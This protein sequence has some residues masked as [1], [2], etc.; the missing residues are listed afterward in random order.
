MIAMANNTNQDQEVLSIEAISAGL[1]LLIGEEVLALLQQP[2]FQAG[3]DDLYESSSWGTV[4]QSRSFV[5]TWYEAYRHEYLPILVMAEHQ[6]KLI[7][8]LTMARDK[9]GHIVGAGHFEAEYQT[10]LSEKAIGDAFIQAALGALMERFPRHELLFRFLPPQTPLNWLTG[11]NK[12]RRRS[13]LVEYSRPLMNFSDPDFS[14]IARHS[15]FRNKLNRLKRLGEVRFERIKEMEKFAAILDRLI[16]LFDFRQGAM[17]NLSQFRD[18]PMKK[19]MLL[20]QFK[21]NL[22]H[23]TVLKVNEEIIAAMVAFAGK[24]WVHLLGVNCHS[25]LYTK[26]NSPGYLHFVML[27]QQLEQEGFECF[28]LTPGYDPYKERLATRHDHVH[29]LVIAG[30][31]F[32]YFKR[33][34]RCRIQNKLVR[35]GLRPMSVELEIRKR[36]YL[37]RRRGI[38][39]SLLYWIRGWRKKNRQRLYLLKDLSLYPSA[40]NLQK[41]SLAD[42]LNFEQGEGKLTRWEFL[43]DAMRRFEAGGHCYT[44]AEEDRLLG[45]VWLYGPK[46]SPT[47]DTKGDS[48]AGEAVQLQGFYCHPTGHARLQAFMSAVAA[49]VSGEGKEG[50]VYA[51]AAPRDKVICHALEAIGFAMA[52]PAFIHTTA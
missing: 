7:G 48:L 46:T 29:E 38:A 10:W 33:L 36:L 47:D 42:L 21:E 20:A 32:F 44:W 15:Q 23:A 26:T 19:E 49:A 35:V 24:G 22:L 34:M 9:K 14:K 16:L 17:F 13:V 52:D 43:E 6:G 51:I 5:A 3:W 31:S 40:Y 28:D 25:P 27:G 12:W 1:K 41:D 30:T 18:E 39:T 45:C 50:Q 4:F 8:L 11:D 37:L 2:G